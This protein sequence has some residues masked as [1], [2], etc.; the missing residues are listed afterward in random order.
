MPSFL[1]PIDGTI[2]IF[3]QEDYIQIAEARS[4]TFE[5]M[6]FSTTLGILNLS[7]HLTQFS[8]QSSLLLILSITHTFNYNQLLIR[9]IKLELNRKIIIFL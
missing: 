3:T 7:E 4:R 5:R 1:H 6:I 8:F 9:L 2:Y